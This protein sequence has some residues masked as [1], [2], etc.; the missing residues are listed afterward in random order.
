MARANVGNPKFYI[1]LLS[2]LKASGL[3]TSASGGGTI[4]IS[5]LIGLAPEDYL[6]QE[7]TGFGGGSN[8][9]A[10]E[11]NLE[12]EYRVSDSTEQFIA[13][14]NH[15]FLDAKIDGCR[16]EFTKDGSSTLTVESPLEVCNYPPSSTRF[17]YNG[18]SIAN[19][20]LDADIFDKIEILLHKDTS[21]G[22][23]EAEIM[24]GSIAWGQ[25]F[26]MPHS[27]N[28]KLTMTREYDGVKSI[29]SKGGSTLTQVNYNSPPL[30]G[31]FP[32]WY[33]TDKNMI[34]HNES[35]KE[36][37]GSKRGRKVWDLE[38]SYIDSGNLFSSNESL[39]GINP[40]D[41]DTY[42][43]AGYDSADFFP[44]TGD[45]TSDDF[46]S[47]SFM[48]IVMGKTMGGALP[49]IFQP[50]GNNN[51]PDQFALCVIDQ[52][53]FQFKQV[54]NQVY[55]IKLKIRESW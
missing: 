48:N 33:I 27:P 22:I 49:F 6:I 26:Q 37:R 20:N 25:V 45:F 23:T 14:L 40:T 52:K 16:V 2:Y 17:S 31:A 44:A 24:I 30:W 53:S 29:T 13:I 11:F 3:M 54:A 41:S 34:T 5:K 19:Y 36:K 28:L 42:S 50:D 10:N 51:S 21:D 1:D 4:D 55:N 46:Q 32:P 18:F 35:Y 12:Q 38:F 7:A 47:S 39:S 15:N 9:W 8:Y 43:Q